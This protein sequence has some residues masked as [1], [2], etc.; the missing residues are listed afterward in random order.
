MAQIRTAAQNAQ[1]QAVAAS[2]ARS[3][4]QALENQRLQRLLQSAREIKFL[5][6]DIAER[7]KWERSNQAQI[8]KVSSNDMSS[9]E[10]TT[11]NV[12]VKRDVPDPFLEA[13]IELEGREKPPKKERKGFSGLNPFKKAEPDQVAAN[14]FIND[15]LPGLTTPALQSATTGSSS[16]YAGSNADSAGKGGGFFGGLKILKI[17]NK[18]PLAE[19]LGYSEEP[20]FVGSSSS[21]LANTRVPERSGQSLIGGSGEND[22]AVS[23]DE[24]APTEKKGFFSGFKKSKPQLTSA[25]S[26]SRASV[27]APSSRS[28]DGFFG[29]SRN[30]SDNTIDAGLFPDGAADRV[31][32]GSNFTGAYPAD[33]RAADTSFASSSTGEIVMPGEDPKKRNRFNLS[34]PNISFPSGPLANTKP[35]TGQGSGSVPTLT[36]INSAG[37]EYYI[38]TSTAQFMVYGND[39]MSSEV[40][41][42]GSGTLVR[43]T[44]PGEQWASIQLPDGSEGVVQNKFLRAASSAESSGQFFTTA[45]E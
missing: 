15:P 45:R 31:P 6:S 38:V 7:S 27:T 13:M 18:T 33:D 41:A 28:G 14:Q 42:L 8:N 22:G 35:V 3:A 39:Q 24:P 30:K 34:M 16:R 4:D 23:I 29:F 11:G 40:R 20:Q 17:G 43:M 26:G 19:K 2:I 37:T 10:S 25:L 44:K 32:V 21:G 1:G 5:K 9:W 36:T 12:K